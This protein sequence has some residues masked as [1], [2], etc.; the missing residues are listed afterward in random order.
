MTWKQLWDE[1]WHRPQGSAGIAVLRVTFGFLMLYSVT[2][3]MIS[4][5]DWNLI[6]GLV[7]KEVVEGFYPGR[8]SFSIFTYAQSIEQL[9]ALLALN[10]SAIVLLIVGVKT[11]IAAWLVYLFAISTM[12][13]NPLML[14]G[15]DRY[16]VT[17]AM[18]LLIHPGHLHLSI[19]ALRAKRKT[20]QWL[21]EPSHAATIA[22][23]FFQIV[24]AFRYF[25]SGYYKLAEGWK[26]GDI[27]WQI[28]SNDSLYRFDLTFLHHFWGLGLLS[29]GTVLFE[30]FFIPLMLC[31]KTR[32]FTTGAGIL[33][34]AFIAVFLNI[35]L[36]GSL[37]MLGYI[38]FVSPQWWEAN[39]TK[40]KTKYR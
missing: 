37:L 27:L 28:L 35:S 19:D 7:S 34:H 40:L 3:S 22:I 25:G 2:S 13:Y 18:V 21:P 32:P 6:D 12:N 14:Y 39:L 38:L 23:R 10:V 24:F 17:V 29:N 31:S 5:Q 20:P 33:M 30:L 9:E 1:F 15:F 36:F 26:D 16:V 8:L 4:L 11:R